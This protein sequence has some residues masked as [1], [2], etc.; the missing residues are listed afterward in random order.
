MSAAGRRL[1]WNWGAFFATFAWLRYRGLYGWSWAY[2]FLSTPILLVYG[3]LLLNGDSCEAALSTDSR[4]IFYWALGSVLVLGWIV[5]PLVADRL[6]QEPASDKRGGAGSVVGALAV[7]VFLFLGAAV[8]IPGYGSYVYRARVSEGVSLIGAAKA[9]LAEYVADHNGRL[10]ARIDEI[11]STISGRFVK[12]IELKADGTL[13][14]VF[15]D[16]AQLLAGR[17]VLMVPT[18]KDGQIAAWTCR[19]DDLPDKCLPAACRSR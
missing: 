14:A 2:L 9:P 6:R 12:R 16:T 11:A 3:L 1:S 15:S 13:R 7:Q 4:E 5:P 19:S 18:R 10:P 17:S 8:A